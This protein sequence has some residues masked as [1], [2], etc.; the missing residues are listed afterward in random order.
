MPTAVPAVPPRQVLAP[1]DDDGEEGSW[2]AAMVRR[3]MASATPASVADSAKSKLESDVSDKDD[4]AKARRQRLLRRAFG[5]L[6]TLPNSSPES[7]AA[8]PPPPPPPPVRRPPPPPPVLAGNAAEADA[9]YLRKVEAKAVL[10]GNDH[11]AMLN[12]PRNATKEQIKAAY[13]QAVKVFHPDHIP[14][15]L[16]HLAPRVRDIFNAIRDAHEALEDDAR[17]ALYLSSLD[18]P[19]AQPA[20]GASPAAKDT[21]SLEKQAE[22]HLRKREYVQAAEQFAKIFAVS[23]HPSHLAQ[24]AWAIYVDPKRKADLP[25]AIKKLEQALGLD[26][27]NDKACYAMGVIARVQ[28]DPARATKLFK[29][30][31]AANPRHAEAASELRLIELRAKKK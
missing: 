29:T 23:K 19:K 5:N 4:V 17:R 2:N 24:E 9:E 26:P 1:I 30:A 10:L 21:E 11:F 12:V 18:K 8:A 16:A 6:G 15:S 14:P 27:K 28:G 13:L 25:L 7:A 20:P 31:L 22:A 3:P